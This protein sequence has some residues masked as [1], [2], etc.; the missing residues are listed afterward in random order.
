MS[1]RRAV[2]PVHADRSGNWRRPLG[3]V[4]LSAVLVLGVLA[5]ATP[6]PAEVFDWRDIDGQNWM[7][8]VRNQGSAG[9]CWAFSAVAALEAKVNITS[10]E[11][12]WNP[13][14]SE[15][16]LVSDGTAGSATGG[17]EFKALDFFVSTGIVTERELP[18]CGED[19]S[20]D[21]PLED[22]WETRVFKAA[23]GR[24][25][26]A[27]KPRIKY[28]LQTHGPLVTAMDAA[29]DWYWP[30]NPPIPGSGSG[31]GPVGRGAT[32][33]PVGYG[34]GPVGAIDHAVVITGLVDDDAMA[35]GGYWIIKNSWGAGWGDAG[36]GYIK[37]GDVEAHN[38]VHAIDGD[39][40]WPDF[41]TG[42]VNRDGVID[43][44]DIDRLFDRLTGPGVP[45][46]ALY[47]LDG[48]GDADNDDVDVLVRNI[49]GTEY[50]DCDLDY[51]I[52]ST[53][54]AILAT[55]FGQSSVAWHKG[56]FNGDNT[57]NTTD[58]TILATNFGFVGSGPNVPEPASLSLLAIATAAL[59][60]RRR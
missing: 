1:D 56:D 38:R 7:S 16:H 19:P 42:D 9:T 53:D 40:T 29:T 54:L 13:D 50:G 31:D 41:D 44:A 22:G 3:A 24:W 43:T 39:A 6:A 59:L 32:D 15:Q 23:S 10:G 2:R 60:K 47:D 28:Y 18:Y 14:L 12:D 20:P 57:V 45:A 34:A 25:V 33:N 35:E 51:A 58:L 17:W 30:D 27:N 55:N 26:P 4:C 49:I 46:D 48:D 8:P 36:Y 21:W 5:I 52:T 37:Y 11:A